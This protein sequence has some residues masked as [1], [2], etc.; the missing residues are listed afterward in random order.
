M[1]RLCCFQ[2]LRHV[3]TI[4]WCIIARYYT[5]IIN[6]RGHPWELPRSAVLIAMGS[7]LLCEVGMALGVRYLYRRSK[8]ETSPKMPG[9][10]KTGA[11]V[12]TFD[13]VTWKRG[14]RDVTRRECLCFCFY[15]YIYHIYVQYISIS[16][17]IYYLFSRAM[18]WW[19][20]KYSISV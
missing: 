18:L 20:K 4:Q 2:I 9:A 19:Y 17:L 14:L 8:K 13:D 11:W 10:L 7:A 16:Y 12:V 3:E 6:P 1:L 5:P 15:I